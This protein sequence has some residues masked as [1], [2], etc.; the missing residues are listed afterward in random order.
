MN[1]RFRALSEATTDHADRHRLAFAPKNERFVGFDCGAAGPGLTSRK[2]GID[3][4][5]EM[6]NHACAGRTAVRSGLR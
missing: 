2:A 3:S 1:A 4:L 6:P 5:P